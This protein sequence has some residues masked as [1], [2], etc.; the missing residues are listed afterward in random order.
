MNTLYYGDKFEEP[1]APN[2]KVGN[3]T[4]SSSGM[5]RSFSSGNNMKHKIVALGL[6]V[7]LS[8]LPIG[9]VLILGQDPQRPFGT[10]ENVKA[11][12]PGE[13]LEV[14]LKSGKTVKGE[15]N[16][17]SDAEIILGRGSNAVTIGRPEV[18]RVSQVVRKS[19][20]KSILVGALVG[21]GI[22]AG[23]GAIAA[24]ADDTGG[25]EGELG[26]ALAAI[27][28]AGAGVGALIG[29]IFRKKKKLVLIYE[30]P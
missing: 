14:Q 10:W 3:L 18:Q 5:S 8:V 7:V 11:I 28:L 20:N 15:L 26:T 25:T 22:A 2:T 16:S 6:T 21:A 17:A 9:Q 13:R 23:G 19:S 12:A 4:P 29:T 30:S 1:V 27:T 24:A